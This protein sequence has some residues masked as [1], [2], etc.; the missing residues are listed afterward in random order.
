VLQGRKKA[1]QEAALRDSF[2]AKR[3]EKAAKKQADI[4][5]LLFRFA[6]RNASFVLFC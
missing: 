4:E 2:S 6:E 1:D 3:E 5:A